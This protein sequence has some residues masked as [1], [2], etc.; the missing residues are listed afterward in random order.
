MDECIFC[1]KPALGD[2]DAALI[3]YRGERCFV[4]LNA[5]PYTNGHLMVAPYEHTAA[6]RGARRGDG[7]SS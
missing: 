7:R 3:P 5:F 4:M 1:S 2:D 6:P